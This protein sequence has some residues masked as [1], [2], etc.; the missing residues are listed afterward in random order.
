M[1]FDQIISLVKKM[2]AEAKAFKHELYK[3]CWFMRG[4]VSVSEIYELSF[5][6]R[7]I[8]GKIIKENMEITKESGMP[9]F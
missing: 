1:P 8:I 5:E 6:D 7:E 3:L 9:F 4:S 2:A